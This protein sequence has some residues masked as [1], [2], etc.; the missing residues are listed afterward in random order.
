[1]YISSWTASVLNENMAAAKLNANVL[2]VSTG[3]G[4]VARVLPLRLL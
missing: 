3:N 2:K 1:M 4:T